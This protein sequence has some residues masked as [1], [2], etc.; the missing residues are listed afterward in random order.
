MISEPENL[1]P[2]LQLW[3]NGRGIDIG[4]YLACMGNFELAIAFANFFWPA[5][6]EHD[7][8][9]LRSDLRTAREFEIYEQW[10]VS[11]KNN[12]T[13]IESVMNHVHILD[14]FPNVET[15]PTRE[16]ILYVGRILNDMW[17]AK[18]H[19]DFPNRNVI[20]DFTDDCGDDLLEYQ[21]TCFQQR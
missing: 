7:G 21:I 4:G 6:F 3:N 16:Q 13:A 9:I 20:I 2:E 15:P 12:K 1:I 19:K 10:K 11:T 17:T 18:L 14:I 8:C 5:F